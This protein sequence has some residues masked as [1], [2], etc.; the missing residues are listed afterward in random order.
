MFDV[1]VSFVLGGVGYFLK[2]F[3]WPLVPFILCFMLGPLTERS[4]I[5][6]MAIPIDRSLRMKTSP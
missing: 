2:S 4:F 5:Q 3:K 6:S 1:L